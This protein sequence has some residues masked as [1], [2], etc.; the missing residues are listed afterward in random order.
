MALPTV[1]MSLPA[2]NLPLRVVTRE[3]ALAAVHANFR[4]SPEE[5]TRIHRLL[6]AVLNACGTTNRHIEEDGV[7]AC[8]ERASV[9]VERLLAEQ[10]IALGPGAIDLV[11]YGS[12]AREYFEPATASEIAAR[13]HLGEP[14]CYDILAACAGMVM[15]VQDVLGRF[16]IDDTLSTAIV[17]T[18]ALSAGRLNDDIQTSEDVGLYGAGLT[19]GNAHTATLISRERRVVDGVA[20]PAGRIV[21]LYSRTF[22]QH[23]GLCTVP[24]YGK[25]RS[26]SA[27]MFRLSRYFPEALG[28]TCR[29]AG[30]SVQD[31]DLFVLHQASDRALAQIA[32]ALQV[33][34]SKV[35]AIHG[36]YGNCESSSAALTLRTLHDRGLIQP[37][38]KLIIGTAA[39]GFMLALIGVE[40]A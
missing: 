23:H 4:G 16:A 10:G 24:V 29:R 33:P 25:F 5:W 3:Q 36:A 28:E 2:V 40:W 20:L 15:G 11:V 22:P 30:W 26:Q 18:A 12:I 27:E 39:A 37:G 6:S 9:A 14:L 19:V 31:V 21:S 34:T 38:M 8:G 32:A 17:A 7:T 35:P 13:S 1:W